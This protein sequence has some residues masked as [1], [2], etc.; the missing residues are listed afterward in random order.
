MW[1]RAVNPNRPPVRQRVV[2]KQRY[3]LLA[4]MRSRAMS[5]LCRYRVQS[6][7]RAR[8]EVPIICATRLLKRTMDGRSLL[9]Q[10]APVG[11]DV[12]G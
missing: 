10:V 3:S 5:A 12:P 7:R 1:V 4:Q 6:G 9:V 8:L 11:R 2:R